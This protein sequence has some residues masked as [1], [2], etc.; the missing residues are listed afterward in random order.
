MTMNCQN[1]Q[2][3]GQHP[4]SIARR[5]FLRDG[6]VGLGSLMLSNLLGNV[7][8][9]ATSENGASGGASKLSEKRTPNAAKFAADPLA[10]K[11]PQYAAKAKRVIYLFMAGAP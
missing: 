10:P 6:G 5:W 3:R 4:Q 8:G 1:H 11:P 2:H 9:A 7:A